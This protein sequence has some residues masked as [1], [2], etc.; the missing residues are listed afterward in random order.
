MTTNDEQ[1]IGN[2]EN[3]LG[4]FSPAATKR[5]L[6]RTKISPSLSTEI[7]LDSMED[8]VGCINSIKEQHNFEEALGTQAASQRNLAIEHGLN[9]TIDNS[10]IA[11]DLCNGIIAPMDTTLRT[12]LPGNKF[13]ETKFGK[14]ARSLIDVAAET[15]ALQESSEEE[16]QPVSKQ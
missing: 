6:T 4:N 2:P 5:I 9:D 8:C 10:P 3:C 15:E 13:L 12:S 7:V 1:M 11:V 14:I 16:V